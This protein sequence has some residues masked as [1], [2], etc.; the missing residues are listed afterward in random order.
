M[1][2]LLYFLIKWRP[3]MLFVV[4]VVLSCVLLFS[5]NPY[6]HSV[7]L[8]SANSVSSGIYQT[9]T[10][11]TSYFNLRD[12][13]EDL[14]RRSA[15]MEMEMMDLR[16]RLQQYEELDYASRVKPDSALRRYEFIVAHVINNSVH[17]PHNY[18]TLNKGSEDGIEPDMGVVDQNGIVG[19]VN[20]VGPHYCRVISFLNDN[21]RI[22]AKLKGTGLVGSL[23]WGGTD[24]RWAMLQELPRHATFHKGDTIVTSGYST[25][26]PEGV[27]VGVIDGEMRDYDENFYTLK[28]K[29]FTDFTKLSTV[30]V[31]KDR[32]AAELNAIEQDPDEQQH[33]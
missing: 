8:T 1:Q 25:T 9:A 22:S 16:N 26:F 7:Y 2:N 33:P 6:Q 18:L 5:G 14:Q 28:V 3:W 19:K 12:I 15:D 23:V 4:Y 11:V 30:R 10:N 24:P 27:P 17:R 20:V 29:L 21:L 31:I 13:N 32:M